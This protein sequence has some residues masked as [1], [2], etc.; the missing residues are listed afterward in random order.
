MIPFLLTDLATV[1]AW[2][3]VASAVGTFILALGIV[4]AMIQLREQRVARRI[5]T[6]PQLLNGWSDSA[7]RAW[8]ARLDKFADLERNRLRLKRVWGYANGH[9]Q[10]RRKLREEL[11][12]F[13]HRSSRVAEEIEVYVRR[14]AA[15]DGI[16]AEHIGYGIVM[17]YY[18]LGDA[19]QEL[20]DA[21]N[22][23]YEGWRL[24]AMRCQTYAKLNPG[25]TNLLN[26]FIWADLPRIRY[27]NR[28]VRDLRLSPW[29]RLRLKLAR[30]KRR[31]TPQR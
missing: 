2:A 30:T 23:D 20:V 11:K 28:Q 1:T 26:E 22:R 10:N 16:V 14:G 4:V 18:I 25:A 13:I 6:T 19:M 12:A 27:A 7:L 24:L 9:S 8:R 21:E 29:E 5:L 31:G 15:D 3:A 17:L